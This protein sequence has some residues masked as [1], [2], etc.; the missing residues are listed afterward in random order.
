VRLG[1]EDQVELA[2]GRLA[3]SNATLVERIVRLAELAGRT[4]ASPARARELLGLPAR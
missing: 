1:F 3:P 4:V 2:P